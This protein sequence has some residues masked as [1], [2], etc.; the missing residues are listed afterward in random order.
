[1]GPFAQELDERLIGP[2]AGEQERF[3]A[4]LVELAQDAGH[5]IGHRAL[6]RHAARSQ[7]DHPE[8][9]ALGPSRPVIRGP[10]P[11]NRGQDRV[12]RIE[13]VLPRSAGLGRGIFDIGV[14]EVHT[15]P[16]FSLTMLPR[17]SRTSCKSGVPLKI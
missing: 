6:I 2:G 11:D 15:E 5:D 10:F 1:M 14:N 16:F 3:G 8:V 13:V 12:G 17:I 4:R 9:R 7:N